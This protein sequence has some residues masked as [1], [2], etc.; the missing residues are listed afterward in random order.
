MIDLVLP[1]LPM[2]NLWQAFTQSGLMGQTIVVIQFIGSIFVWALMIGK[3]RELRMIDTECRHFLRAFTGGRDTLDLYLG[4]SR[5]TDNSPFDVI[6]QKTCDRLVRLFDHDVRVALI[7]RRG[8]EVGS[9]ALSAR[10]LALVSGTSE[11]ML[12][13]QTVRVERGMSMLASATTA[14]PLMGLLGTV[15]GVLEAFQIVAKIGSAQLAEMAPAISAALLT[16]VVGLLVAIP[17][18]IGYNLLQSRTRSLVIDLE[19]FTDELTARISCE[20]QGKGE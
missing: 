18:G 17:S 2:A 3:G 19:G 4:Q 7:G 13:E 15:W 5:R 6:Y 20:F 16:T 12:A 8:G 14:A 1:A 10:E 11:H 9:S